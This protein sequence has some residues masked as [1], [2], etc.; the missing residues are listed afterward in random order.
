MQ[1]QNSWCVY[2]VKILAEHKHGLFAEV[3][4]AHAKFKMRE[5]D[6]LMEVG[7]KLWINRQAQRERLR[8]LS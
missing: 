2:T 6:A 8:E 4:N 7:R 5:G 3:L 1:Y